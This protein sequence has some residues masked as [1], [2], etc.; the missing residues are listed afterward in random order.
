[1]FL[2]LLRR[3]ANDHWLAVLLAWVGLLVGLKLV[4]PSW[5]DVALDGDLDYLPPS[6]TSRQAE[7]LLAEAFPDID[8][9]SRVVLLVARNQPREDGKSTLSIKDR[10]YILDLSRALE[11]RLY[12]NELIT[13]EQQT[14]DSLASKRREFHQQANQQQQPLA[15]QADAEATTAREAAVVTAGDDAYYDWLI[16]QREGLAQKLFVDVWN[17]KTEVVNRMLI[18]PQ[19]DAEIIVARMTT[20][21]MEFKNIAIR[22]T[23]RDLLQEWTPRAKQQGLVLGGTG[24]TLLG[25][26]IRSA[27]L[28]SLGNTEKTTVVLVLVCLLAI[29]RAP[30]L[31][32][33]P[34]ATIGVSLSVAYDVVALMAEHF[35]PDDYSWSSLK[36]FTTTKIFVVVILFGAGT[37]YCLFLI[38]RY[39]EE[40]GSGTPPSEAPGQALA[41]VADA[42]AGSAFTTILGLGTMAFADFGKFVSSGPIIGICLTVALAACVT[43][44]PALLRAVG[45][46]VFW[47][48]TKKVIQI[49]DDPHAIHAAPMAGMWNGIST[50]VM[51]YPGAILA[52]S[53]LVGAPVI[54][55]GTQ[56]GVTHNLLSELPPGSLSVVGADL[57]GEYFGKGWT[58]PLTIVAEIP[59]EKIPRNDAGQTLD[60]HTTEGLYHIARLHAEL[61]KTYDPN[62]PPENPRNIVSDVRSL[63]Y[64]TGGD[65]ENQRVLSLRA[66]Q[67]ATAAGSPLAADTFVSKADPYNGR[68]TQ[69]SLV[70]NTDPF[71]Q[72]ARDDLP[73]LLDKLKQ[74][75]AA[76][77]LQDAPNAWQGARFDLAGTTPGLFDLQNVTNADRT[78]I[79]LCTVTAVFLVLVV[80][81]RRPLA[82]VYLIITVLLS[83]WATIG[84][85][86]W[87]FQWFYGDTFHGL[88]WKVPIF[89]FVILIAVGQDY[90]IYLTTRVFEEQKNYGLA[91][92]LRR[93]IV[94]TGG[95]ITSC[96]VIMAGTF[97]SMSTG[98]LRAM[99]ELG[100]SLALGV[101]LDTFFVRTIIVPCYFALVARFQ[102]QGVEDS[103]L[104]V[105]AATEPT[106]PASPTTPTTAG[107]PRDG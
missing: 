61:F 60:L 26:D 95:I 55:K 11:S 1:M 107:G 52:A 75:S 77:T 7:A 63:R 12:E 19:K 33:V 17:E 25:G 24:S 18:S 32:L 78:R 59:A 46:R 53:L 56:V 41:N 83:Y 14:A 71:G 6:V 90:N 74:I 28:E 101:L 38:S 50:L 81:M 89:L 79:Q 82:C 105:P 84:M 97:I 8:D 37:D 27:T 10:Q 9:N 22:N 94:Q 49:A 104:N 100:F 102:G 45:V 72:Q 67:E 66:L 47:P 57:V 34:M 93:A 36:V 21:L 91:A 3:L 2:A 42:L 99:V 96:G 80:L 92:G 51:K 40:L 106:R 62:S 4:A 15:D 48:F 23:V 69:L 5:E 85:T 98:S 44:A 30:M 13:G 58:S 39:K 103:L 87:F 73:I 88:D 70:L 29:Y 54:V 76:D 20:G 31:I 65:P 43:F 86:E 64:P 35:G 16:A 68:V